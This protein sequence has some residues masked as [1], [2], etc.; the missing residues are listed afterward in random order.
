MKKIF[1]AFVC[2]CASLWFCSAGV[3]ALEPGDLRSNIA[4]LMDAQTGQVLFEKNAEYKMYPA[5]TTKIMTALLVAENCPPYQIVTVSED[6][7]NIPVRGS[8]NIELQPGEELSVDEAMYAMMLASANDAANVLAEHMAG[9]Q[10]EFARMMTDRAQEIGAVHTR[11]RNAHGLTE[12][13]HYTTAHDLALITGYACR[14]PTFLRYFGAKE[15]VMAPTGLHPKERSFTNLQSMLIE[16]S[17]FYDPDV[18]GGKVG[19]TNRSQHTMSTL[20]S[21]NG[22]SLIVVVGYS[23]KPDDKFTDTRKLLDYGFTQF[24]EVVVPKEEFSGF[25]VPVLDSG[26]P[27]GKAFFTAKRDFYALIPQGMDPKGVRVRLEHPDVFEAGESIGCTAHFE[28]QRQGMEPVS[29]G[30]VQ[31][32]SRIELDL[33]AKKET[34]PQ[35]ELSEL[36]RSYAPPFTAALLLLSLVFTARNRYGADRRRNSRRPIRRNRALRASAGR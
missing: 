27:A 32:T 2:A 30:S 1:A 12:E 10:Q 13:G 22:R 20:A 16:D 17:K 34:S 18:Q 3:S 9:T 23:T 31:L 35:I 11:F 36:L 28:L 26:N 19:F 25:T 6:A 33:P 14:N 7:V 29:L 5:S 24:Q 8:T 21:R 4:I 15:Y